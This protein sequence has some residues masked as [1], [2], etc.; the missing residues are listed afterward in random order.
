MA[1]LRDSGMTAMLFE[2]EG[3]GERSDASYI[4]SDDDGEVD[5]ILSDPESDFDINSD[6]EEIREVPAVASRPTTA[7]L[8]SRDG[9][10]E[11]STTPIASSQGRTSARNIFRE[12][13][14]PTRYAV[15]SCT[16]VSDCFFLFFSN[17]YFG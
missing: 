2:D 6:D 13:S 3:E 14:G 9:K 16:S 11:W 5:M 4:P 10:E 7:T 15:R 12:N 1:N 17:K 8:K